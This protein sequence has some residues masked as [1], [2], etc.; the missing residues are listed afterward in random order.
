MPRLIADISDFQ[1]PLNPANYQRVG[2]TGIITK[3]TES[4]YYATKTHA[5][6][7]QAARDAGMIVGAYHFLHL[8]DPNQADWYLDHVERAWGGHNGLIHML[9]V[10]Q[11]YG[12]KNPDIQDVR[13][14]AD[15]FYART[16]GTPYSSTAV[17]GI[18]VIRSVIRRIPVKPS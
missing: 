3:V 6:N 16:N 5:H 15:R 17:D 10:E 12:G 14:F 8:R 1:Q 4:N 7:L 2:I 13:A 11:E 9:D 18:G